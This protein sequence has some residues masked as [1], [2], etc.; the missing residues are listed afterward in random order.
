ME[1][2]LERAINFSLL[3]CWDLLLKQVLGGDRFV[4]KSD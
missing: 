3:A 2:T 1:K 4:S